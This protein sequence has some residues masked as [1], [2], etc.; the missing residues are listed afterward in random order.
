MNTKRETI[1]NKIDTIVL[2]DEEDNIINTL[3]NWLLLMQNK[4]AT[5]LNLETDDENMT[6]QFEAYNLIPETDEQYNGRVTHM[7]Q[8]WATYQHRKEEKDRK[9]YERLKAKYG[10]R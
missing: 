4:G 10:N 2:K 3:S 6:F 1:Y 5:S 9:E 8:A 7:K